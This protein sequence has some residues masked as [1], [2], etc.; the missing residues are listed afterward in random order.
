M[1]EM[2]AISMVLGMIGLLALR[3]IF[4]FGAV[5]WCTDT[6]PVVVRSGGS[7]SCSMQGR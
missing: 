7:R 6:I 2:V 4:M 3:K 5:K 1:A